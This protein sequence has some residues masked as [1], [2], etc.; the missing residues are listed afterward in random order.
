MTMVRTVAIFPIRLY[1]RLISPA[2]PARCK[3][4]PSCSQYA[5]DA[6]REVGVLRGTLLAAW[7]LARCNPWS[8][9]G[10]D[11]IESRPFFRDSGPH[12]RS[13]SREAAA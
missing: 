5:V 7:R 12:G 8:N 1:Q 2:I 10:I 9:G 4:H 13:H 6:V 11:P 3:Y